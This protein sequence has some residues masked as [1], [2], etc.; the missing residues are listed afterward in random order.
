[1]T[2]QSILASTITVYLIV[3]VGCAARGLKIIDDH[4]EKSLMKL[5]I[6]ILFPCFI[7]SKVPGNPAL[8][9][10][11][12]VGLAFLIG[13]AT[14]VLSVIICYFVGKLAGIGPEMGLSTFALATAL[15]NYGF[16]PIPLIESIYPALQSDRI[17]GVLFIHNLGIET[18]IWTGGIVLISGSA[19]G[20]WKRVIN[21]P[22]VAITLGLLFNA[23]GAW[24]YAPE[25]L[26]RATKMVGVCAIPVAL[27][28]V[29][30]TL[31][32]VIEREKWKPNWRVVGLSVMLRYSLLPLLL[33][34]FAW[35]IG[36]REI[37]AELK[38]V[39]LIQAAMPCAI[40]PIVL[41]KHYG[42]HPSVAVQIALATSA[43]S[44]VLTPLLLAAWIWLLETP[45][46]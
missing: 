30:A 20:A 4:S 12:V 36:Q 9:Q 14:V 16:I 31:A 29:G 28:M 33:I 13:I 42:G 1:M 44:L 45:A 38:T 15:Q 46:V 23:T 19:Q 25:I 34:G 21:G 22:S 7:L 27:I 24:A 18:A 10:S 3:G 11:S 5:V 32:G 8:Q 37:S 40:F 17:L 6:N 26:V 35:M 41:A 39:L 2:F 43:A